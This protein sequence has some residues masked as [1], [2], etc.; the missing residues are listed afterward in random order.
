MKFVSAILAA[1]SLLAMGTAASARPHH[2]RHQVCTTH[3]HH[4]VCHWA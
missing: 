2:H 4:K 1:V 3:H